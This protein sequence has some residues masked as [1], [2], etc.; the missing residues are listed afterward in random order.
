M[1]IVEKFCQFGDYDSDDDFE[2]D[3]EGDKNI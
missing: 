2:S 1:K 3:D